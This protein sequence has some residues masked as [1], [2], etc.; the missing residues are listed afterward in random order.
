MDQ[1][2][3][4]FMSRQKNA[5]RYDYLESLKKMPNNRNAGQNSQKNNRNGQNKKRNAGQKR[6]KEIIVAR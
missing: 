1:N 4:P 3:I 6:E 2:S 5:P